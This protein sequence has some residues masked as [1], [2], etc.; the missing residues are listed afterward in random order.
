M[1]LEHIEKI[2]TKNPF[3]RDYNEF[4]KKIQNR[5]QI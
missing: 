5:I 3:S 4:T 1:L 2:D